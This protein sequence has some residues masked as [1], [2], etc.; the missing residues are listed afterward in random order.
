MTAKTD[1]LWT[2]LTALCLGFIFLLSYFTYFHRFAEPAGFF[3]DENYHITSAEKYLNGT[4][5]MQY[6]PPLGKLLIALGEKFMDANAEDNQFL[7]IDYA[8]TLPDGFSFVGYRLFPTL[9][10]WLTAPLLFF[11]FLFIFRKP[12]NAT[13]MSFLYVFDN[14]LIVHSRGAMLE[15]PLVF[16]TTLTILSF[17][18]LLEWQ[19][20]PK[21]FLL[22]SIFFGMSLG[23]SVTTKVVGLILI[24]LV[25]AVLYALFPQWK[26]MLLFLGLTFSA[27]LLTFVAVWQIHF[28]LATTINPLA[29]NNGWYQTSPEY[30]EILTGK[31]QNSLFS[32]PVMLR[33]S[34]KYVGHVDRGVPKLDLC[35]VGENG[36]PFFFW[37]FG[38]RAINYRWASVD[39][40]TYRYLYLQSNPAAWALGLLGVLLAVT[41]LLSALFFRQKL[42][43][44]FLLSTFLALYISYMIAISQLDRVMYLYHYFL[45][46]LFSFI[47]FGIVSAEVKHIGRFSLSE[48]RK[49]MLLM[50]LAACI[51]LSYQIYRPLTYYE[52]ITNEQ[53]QKRAFFPLWELSCVTCERGSVLGS[54][55]Q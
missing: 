36:S 3:W 23:L 12:I 15:S 8:T 16:F 19:K 45:P 17:F 49:T 7:A 42:S 35:K 43:H 26:K 32:F 20:S 13:L 52:P 47:L 41:F 25:P 22:A 10:A 48:A 28:S 1:K 39:A 21:R 18:L 29:E 24:L 30:R 40:E 51:F 44:T 6:H 38:A 5:F 27:F 46:L 54:P 50:F 4:F 11:V 53:L 9:L 31:K 33:D 37:P 14:A 2:P 34:L 55:K